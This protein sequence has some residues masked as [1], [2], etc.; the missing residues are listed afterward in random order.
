[1][2]PFSQFTLS[3]P[4]KDTF[5]YEN[6]FTTI[7]NTM[8]NYA[9]SGRSFRHGNCVGAINWDSTWEKP[10]P[11][12]LHRGPWIG[13]AG[14]GYPAIPYL[15]GRCRRWGS[16]VAWP[17]NDCSRKWSSPSSVRQRMPLHPSQGSHILMSHW[18][19]WSAR[20]FYSW[21]RCPGHISHNAP[22]SGMFS[23]E[24]HLLWGTTEQ[25]AKV[26]WIPGF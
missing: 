25:M 15:Q 8:V 10:P 19:L 20:L 4:N 7:N 23:S 24:G 16:E 9:G 5:R 17:P 2:A 22:I 6:I 21:L 11:L 14:M 12:P 26:S 18:P 1:M 13:T 3:T